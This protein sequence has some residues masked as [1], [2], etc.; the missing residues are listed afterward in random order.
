M[1]SGAVGKAISNIHNNVARS[2][3]YITNPQKTEK[4]L[5]V[6]GVNCYQ[7]EDFVKTAKEF[8]Q[9]RDKFLKSKKTNKKP[10]LAHHYLIS[11]DPKDNVDSQKAHE[12]SIKIIDRFLKKQYQAVL[13]THIDKKSHIHTHIIF[14]TYNK[15]NGRKYESSP[16]KLREFKKVINEVCLEHDLSLINKRKFEE[17]KIDLNYGEWLKRNNII[18]DKKIERFK[19]VRQAIKSILK[20]WN[21][22]SLDEFEKV[23]KKQYG[24]NIKYKNY[25]TNELYKNITFKAD[26]WEKGLRG[27]HDISLDNIIAQL[28]GRKIE[29]NKFQEYCCKNNTEN[30]KLYIKNAIDTELENNASIIKIEDLVDTLKRKYNIEM[31]FCNKRGFYLQRFKFKALDSKQKNFIGTLSLDKENRDN[32]EAQGIKTRIS[33]TQE[34]KFGID[35]RENLKILNRNLL[36]SG[37]E[38]KW[39]IA[40]GLNYMT[41]R[42]LRI[43]S[44]IDIRRTKLSTIKNNNEIQIE[45]IN[46]Y[47]KQMELIYSRLQKK[48]V[49]LKSLENEVSELNI[50][51]VKQKKYLTKNIENIKE[52][53]KN[54][55]ESP[56][57]QKEIKYSEKSEE[58]NNEKNKYIKIL[59]DCDLEQSLLYTIETI[60][61]TKENIMEKLKLDYQKEQDEM[62][63]EKNQMEK[64]IKKILNINL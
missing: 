59:K 2:L 45:K 23:L 30:Y 1:G 53:I 3:D 32:Y 64:D 28:E 47:I 60:D 51:K 7:P 49:E 50:F 4:Q 36:I 34:I 6:S 11:F 56:F 16:A 42:N 57:Y 61:N 31:Q 37:K 26:D 5:L 9:I 22:K 63:Q 40:T 10:I 20:D 27:K 21:I 48:V 62:E 38:D 19:Y 29:S 14:N 43:S 41:K 13:S 18:D 52:D 33:K 25:K 46:K 8:K 12:L 44:D 54:L 24:L 55:K 15:N 39:G 58:L 17:K 35:I